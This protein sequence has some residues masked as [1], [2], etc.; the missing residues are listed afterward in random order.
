MKP[1]RAGKTMKPKK[2]GETMKMTKTLEIE[3]LLERECRTA[4]AQTQIFVTEF[5]W[6]LTAPTRPK[7]RGIAL[8]GVNSL[9]T[10]FSAHSF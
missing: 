4:L 1:K 9:I 3:A 8:R 5:P 7:A 10:K 2:V 6:R